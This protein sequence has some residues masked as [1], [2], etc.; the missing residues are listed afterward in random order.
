MI[1]VLVAS[2]ISIGVLGAILTI[3]RPVQMVLRADADLA[4]MHQR[5]RAVA[6]TIAGSIRI[7]ESIRPYRIGVIR[8]DGSAGVYYRPDAIAILSD[9]ATTYYFKAET[10]QLMQYDGGGSDLPV[11]DHVVRLAFDYFGP[12]VDPGSPLVR[13]DPASLV[14]GPWLQDASLRR[15]DGDVLRISEVRVDL[16]LE[17]TAPSLRSLVPDEDLTF[18]AALRNSSGAR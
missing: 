11:I 13:F 14:D 6:D 7:C 9:T 10:G 4:D 8:D 16:R 2:A 5:F 3:V 15:F 1:E 12:A 17:A 18:H